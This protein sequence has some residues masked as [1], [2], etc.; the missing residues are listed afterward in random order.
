MGGCGE[1]RLNDAPGN[2]Y[3]PGLGRGPGA[4]PLETAHRLMAAGQYELALSAYQRAAL[5]DGLTVDTLAGLGSANLHLGRLGQAERWLRQALR[6]DGEFGPAWNNLGVVLMERGKPAEAAEAFRR[7]Y[8]LSSGES[9][10]I[11]DNLRLA[12]ARRD[13]P[14]Y[15]GVNETQSVPLIGFGRESRFGPGEPL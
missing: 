11:R 8:A 2:V 13:D 9:D 1:A 4:D 5:R 15:S 10:T 7:A 6:E 3:A 12:L 14:A